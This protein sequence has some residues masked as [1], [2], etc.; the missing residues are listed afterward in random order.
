MQS[1]FPERRAMLPGD[2]VL[3]ISISRPEEAVPLQ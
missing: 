1:L 2:I 3:Q